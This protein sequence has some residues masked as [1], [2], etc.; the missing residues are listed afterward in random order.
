MKAF[1]WIFSRS[2]RI[3]LNT[4]FARQRLARTMPGE[5][6]ALASLRLTGAGL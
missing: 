3:N 6:G 5:T 4:A 2:R 1:A